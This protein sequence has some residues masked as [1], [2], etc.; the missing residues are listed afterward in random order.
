VFDFA[1]QEL[2]KDPDIS[3]RDLKARAD[4][5]GYKF[6]PILYG[7]AKALLGL[8]AV[9]PRTSKKAAAAAAA[10]P[11]Q[12]RQVDAPVALSGWPAAA[13][14]GQ[15]AAAAV[16]VAATT[17]PPQGPD[18]FARRLDEVRNIEQLVAVVKELDAERRRLRGVLEHVAAT[19]AA[20]LQ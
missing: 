12:L 9:K 17:A 15:V 20:A 19:I 7:R 18:Q 13:P 4:V 8:V 10:A 6:P 1:V 14:A 11:R 5:H 16:G 3:Y 2:R